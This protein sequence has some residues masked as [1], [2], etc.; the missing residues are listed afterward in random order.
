MGTLSKIKSLL[1]NIRPALQFSKGTSKHSSIPGVCIIYLFYAM[2]FSCLTLNYRATLATEEL[3][4][5]PMMRKTDVISFP[6][7]LQ[8]V[9]ILEYI[10][11]LMS[12]LE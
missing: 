6:S 10:S 8:Y 2:Q 5:W 12:F 4:R 3:F 11:S 7:A 9:Y 1:F